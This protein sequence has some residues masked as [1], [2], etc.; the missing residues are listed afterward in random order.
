MDVLKKLYW[1]SLRF[2]LTLATFLAFLLS[3]WTLTFFA[4]S[5]LRSDLERQVG[6]QQLSTARI[7]AGQIDAEMNDRFAAM[8][9]VAA[10]VPADATKTPSVAQSFLDYRYA[11]HPMFN[12]GIVMLNSSGIAVAEYPRSLG[13]LG[14]NYMDRDY[15]LGAIAEGK[16]SVSRPLTGR[17][18]KQA[19]VVM[20]VPIR[21]PAGKVAGALVGITVLDSTNFL[22]RLTT[23]PYGKTGGYLLIAPAQRQVVTATDR[24]RILEVLPP[25]GVNPAIDSFLAGYEGTVRMVSP[26]GVAILASDVRVHAAPWILAAV[27]P[28]EEAFAPVRDMFRNMLVAAILLGLVTAGALW[29]VVRWQ[30]QPLT[31]TVSRLAAMEAPGAVSQALP[32]ARED[33]VGTLIQRFN[34]LLGTLSVRDAELR[35]AQE[36]LR[37]LVDYTPEATVVSRDGKIIFANPSALQI[38]G[39]GHADELLGRDI[40]DFMREQKLL[41][42]DATEVLVESQ[43]K[44]LPFEGTA[45][46]YTFFHDVTEQRRTQLAL[47]ESHAFNISVLD[48]ID[49]QIAVVDA[50]GVIQSVNQA[51]T[52]FAQANGAAR[53]STHSIGLNYLSICRAAPR[54]ANGE[55]AAEALRGLEAV[56]SGRKDSFTLEYPCHS[57]LEQ[58]WFEMTVTRLHGMGGG[59]VIVHK[60]ITTL[61]TV[62]LDLRIAACA[63]E[64]N[65]GMFVTD[66]KSVILRANRACSAITGYAVNELVGS[67][68]SLLRSGQQ[69]QGFYEAMWK[70]ITDA[71]FW[72]GEI[73]NCNKAGQEYTQD[74]TISAVKN[75]AGVAT[76]YVASFSDITERKRMEAAVHRLAFFDALTELPNRRLMQDRL[77]QAMGNNRRTGAYGA[78]MFLDLD[79]F[80]PLNDRHGHEA[81]DRLLIEVANRLTTCVRET[82]SVSRFGGDEFVVMLAELDKDKSVATQEAGL[83]AEKM[84]V[85]LSQTYY[86]RP[87]GEG[88]SAAVEHQCSASIGA[89]LFSSQDTSQEEILKRADQAMYQAKSSGRNRVCF[90]GATE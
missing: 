67:K 55:E 16:N 81:G 53:L 6:A 40:F 15:A 77:R 65:H 23:Q 73:V 1:Q 68:V 11:L 64:C 84:R 82:D 43:S 4:Y 63:F 79:N 52:E 87:G 14:T 2:R 49:S 60:N 37:Q 59:A 62:A 30:F 44:V 86:L 54:R 48:S 21:D 34:Q 31:A 75:A 29:W 10:Y 33:E 26:Q 28:E 78:V 47:Q 58:R 56:L 35:K 66:T 25:P 5:S 36:G 3:A 27:L 41:R 61:K 51:W 88:I 18:V 57:P 71:G 12:S 80:K 42:L 38:L 22:D 39:A 32:V 50:Q 90:D 85:A 74:L 46:I 8:T 72:H 24:S 17:V 70:S 76:N 83:V 20:A 9:A 13:R 69:S 7:L 89:T 45:A 19:G